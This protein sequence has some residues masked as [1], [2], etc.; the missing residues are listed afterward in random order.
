[1]EITKDK[2]AHTS[3]SLNRVTDGQSV[4]YSVPVKEK[5]ISIFP[6]SVSI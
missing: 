6:F 4:L 2:K 5:S 3:L 1:M